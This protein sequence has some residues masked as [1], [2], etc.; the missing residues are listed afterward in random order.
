[1]RA[2]VDEAR[3]KADEA[4]R[5]HERLHAHLT[6]S[7]A[8]AAALQAEV[9][10]AL[11][12]CTESGRRGCPPSPSNSLARAG[13]PLGRAE[14]QRLEAARADAEQARDRD[15]A[16]LSELEQRLHLAETRPMCRPNRRPTSGTRCR[17]VLRRPRQSEMEARLACG[18]ARSGCGQCGRAE[19]LLH[20]AAT[21]RA[22]RL[23]QQKRVRRAPERGRGR[24][25]RDGAVQVLEHIAALTRAAAAERDAAQHHRVVREGELLTLRAQTRE[26]AEELARLT[27]EVH[28][29]E[30]IRAEQRLRVE[31][32]ETRAVEEYGV[33]VETLLAEYGPDQ[34]CPPSSIEVAEFEQAR[35]RG[36]EV[37]APQPGPFHRPTQE[38]RAARAERDP[39]L[40]GKVNPLALEEFA[41]LEERHQ[42]LS[43]QLED[44]KATR[45]I[46]TPSSRRL[47]NGF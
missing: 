12:R 26:L 47:T 14:A 7:R 38:K 34:L 1:M 41:A 45:A 32:L 28:R 2:A 40:F 4:P 8:Q 3:Q 20:A 33:E 37:V 13:G 15:L 29:D 27:D 22:G 9:D 18:P 11:E 36:E 44:L 6:E 17:R 19:Q 10:A 43:T 30:V 16:G 24:P 42:F 25:V 5:R 31:Q 23:R 21:E 35:E 46:C 39:A